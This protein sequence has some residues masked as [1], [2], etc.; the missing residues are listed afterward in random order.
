MDKAVRKHNLDL[1]NVCA[2]LT[3]MVAG[4]ALFGWMANIGPLKTVVPGHP[5]LKPAF[6]IGYLLFGAALFL[7]G[8]ERRFRRPI[9]GI[10]LVA[11]VI[12]AAAAGYAFAGDPAAYGLN[13]G[14]V[15]AALTLFILGLS[16]LLLAC[17]GPLHRASGFLALFALVVSYAV[18]LGGVY[19]ADEFRGFA[20]QNGIAPQAILLSFVVAAGLIRQNRSLRVAQLFA[21]DTL[22]GSAARRLVPFVIVVPTLIG[23]LRVTAEDG[24]LFDNGFGSAAATFTL[25]LVM[26][27]IVIF[28]SVRID[29][30]DLARRAAAAELAEKEMRYRELFDYGQ[31]LICIHDLEGVLGTVNRAAL[32][33]LGYAEDEMVGR[34]LRDF[35]RPERQPDFDAYL[36]TVTHEGIA[37][38]L[39]ELTAKDGRRIVLR[40][41]NILATEEGKEPYVLGHAQD[42]TELLE[43]QRQLRELSLTDDLTGLYNR[44]G[45]L[46]MAEHQLKLE[47]HTGTARGLTVLFADMDGLKAINDT[48]GHEAGSNAIRTLGR[49]VAASV[50]SGDLVARWGGDEIIILSVGAHGEH[51]RLMVDRIQESIDHYNSESREPFSIGCSIGFTSVDHTRGFDEIIAEA[52]KRMYA[53]KRRRKATRDSTASA[54]PS[55][56]RP[57]IDHTPSVWR[58]L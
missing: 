31:G 21:S 3:V 20:G 40:Y 52:D 23:W 30:A 19:R 9:G 54:P 25:V 49:L 46:T 2:A 11:M 13:G 15:L 32:Q 56:V 43:A 42:V 33:M 10:G 4:A 50:R 28:Y 39:L 26:I 6:A 29:E 24:G 7:S 1:V 17:D 34:P 37:N 58:K 48:Y 14:R 47:R 8:Y 41:Y 51:G 55:F 27:G 12:A 5:E 53:E 22:G 18:V 36:R 16:F 45:F 44:R 57:W 35:V 38:G